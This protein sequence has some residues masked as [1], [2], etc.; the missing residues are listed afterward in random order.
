MLRRM[1]SLDHATL[2][3]EERLVLERFVDVLRLRLGDALGA[4]WL[5][6]H[7]ARGETVA[8]RSAIDVL[9]IADGA[10][11]SDSGRVYEAVHDAA[12]ERSDDPATCLSSVYYAA[13]E[14]AQDDARAAVAAADG[15]IVAVAA[16][17]EGLRPA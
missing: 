8:G 13:L 16:M 2:S 7:R 14:I 11:W 10:G 9:V 12:R 15:I 17:L 1:D 6:G 3:A 5:F 4:V